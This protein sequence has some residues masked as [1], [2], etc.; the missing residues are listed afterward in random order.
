MKKLKRLSAAVA[1]TCVLGVAAFAEPCAEPGQTMTPPCAAGQVAAPGDVGSPTSVS[2]A[3]GQIPT[4][5]EAQSLSFTEIATGV[6]Y[7]LLSLF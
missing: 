5:P 6:L 4:P 1:L 3:P 7:S 2:T